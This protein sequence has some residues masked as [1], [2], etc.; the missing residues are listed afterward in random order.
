[1]KL[2]TETQQLVSASLVRMNA[3]SP[4]FAALALFARFEASQTI[5]TACTDGRDIFINPGFFGKLTGAE[6]DGLLAHEVLHAALLHVSRR[7]Q[8][9]PK[10]WNIAADIVINGMLAKDGYALPQGGLR[11][12]QLERLSAEEVYDL[13]LQNAQKIELPLSAADL[14]GER[15]ADA[16]EGDRPGEQ[17]AEAMKKY[18]E[19]AQQQAQ[20]GM[21]ATVHGELP[22]HLTR[23]FGALT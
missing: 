9:D 10:L 3:R 20:V 17:S 15:P 4:F 18:W 21:E 12:E 8:R 1:M 13:I 5:T 16:S 7:Q 22:Q 23:E 11:D 14:I 19:Q 6:Q 2:D